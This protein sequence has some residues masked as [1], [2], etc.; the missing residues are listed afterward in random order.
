VEWDGSLETGHA[1]VDEQHRELIAIFSDIADAGDPGCDPQSVGDLLV[2]LSDYVS[3]HFSAEENLMSRFSYPSENV[4]AHRA[5]H[6][7]LSVRTRELV[8][9][10]RR[11]ETAT[12]LPLVALLQDWLTVHILGADSE[13]V[14]YLR[15]EQAGEAC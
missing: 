12:I 9:A 3:T 10:H 6:E 15:M 2:R 8:L 13:F 1:L 5:Q 4:E 11:G 7:E 14:D